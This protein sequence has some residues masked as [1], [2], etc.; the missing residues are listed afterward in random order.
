VMV[1]DNNALAN[2]GDGCVMKPIG[3]LKGFRNLCLTDPGSTTNGTQVQLQT[4]VNASDQHW[5]VP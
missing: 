2:G 5:S 3:A 4:C 1:Y